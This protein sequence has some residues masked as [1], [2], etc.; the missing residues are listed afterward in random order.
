MTHRVHRN[1]VLLGASALGVVW[2]LAGAAA[3]QTAEPAQLDEFVVTAQLR[4]Q[5]PI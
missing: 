5:D 3:A 4:E 2:G 1:S